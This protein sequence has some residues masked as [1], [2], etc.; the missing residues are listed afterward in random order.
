M[1]ERLAADGASVVVNYAAAQ[2]AAR[3]AERQERQ[4][5][6]AGAGEVVRGVVPLLVTPLDADGAV[7]H[8]DLERLAV[9]QVG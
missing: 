3:E 6:T 7:C 4:M 9:K 8:E 2:A 5:T 1:C